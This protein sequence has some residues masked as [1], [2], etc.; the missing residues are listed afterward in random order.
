MDTDIVCAL[1]GSWLNKLQLFA[2]QTLPRPSV[3]PVLLAGFGS[4]AVWIL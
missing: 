2:S 4:L 3:G 1:L